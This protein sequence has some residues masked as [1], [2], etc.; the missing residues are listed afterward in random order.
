MTRDFVVIIIVVFRG[1]LDKLP[2]VEQE[3]LFIFSQR[4]KTINK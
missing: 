2:E 4:D 3:K 1:L